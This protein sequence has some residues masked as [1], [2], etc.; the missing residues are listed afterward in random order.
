VPT[1][2]VF[3]RRGDALLYMEFTGPHYEG[4]C[5]QCIPVTD[6]DSGDRANQWSSETP[7]V[8]QLSHGLHARPPTPRRIASASTALPR[9]AILAQSSPSSSLH[10]VHFVSAASRICARSSIRSTRSL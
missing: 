1:H 9:N 8:R 6:G 4:H 2:S 3:G 7:Y 5:R 10:R